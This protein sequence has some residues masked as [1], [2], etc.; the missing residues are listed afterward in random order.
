MCDRICNNSKLTVKVCVCYRIF[1]AQ[2]RCLVSKWFGFINHFL[3][4]CYVCGLTKAKCI[5]IGIGSGSIS[6]QATVLV[7]FYADAKNGFYDT[8]SE[9]HHP[10]FV[11]LGLYYPFSRRCLF[12]C[13]F[14]F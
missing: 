9:E 10:L 14:V 5:G 2:T 4:T 6:K 8:F 13:L 3:V 12:V 1:M 11:L 7:K